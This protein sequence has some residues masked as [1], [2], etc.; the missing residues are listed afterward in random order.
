MIGAAFTAACA[1]ISFYLPGNPVPVTM[2]VFAIVLC[3]LALGSRWGALAQM[4]YLAAGLLGAPVFAGFRCGP[5]ALLGP[6]GGYL[7]GFV[8]TAF[9]VGYVF[10]RA[11][12]RT[13]AAACLAGAMGVCAL[14]AFGVAWLSVWLGPGFAGFTPWLLGAAPFVAVDAVKV[15]VAAALCARRTVGCKDNQS[16]QVQ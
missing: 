9:V 13:F 5:A 15:A 11:S 3:G 1:H 12:S 6:T 7:V 16:V 14:Y 10:E 2:Q 8:A 4:E